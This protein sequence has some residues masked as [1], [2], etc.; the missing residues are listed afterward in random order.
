MVRAQPFLDHRDALIA[1][2]LAVLA[3]MCLACSAWAA[4]MEAI[5]NET[6]DH[7]G[8][9][10]IKGPLITGE[11]QQDISK[12]ATLAAA[13][14]NPVAVFLDSPGGSAWAAVEIGRIIRKRGFSTVVIDDATC[15]S[16]CAL[17]WMAGK[18]R[19]MGG[20]TRI[21]FH[22]ARDKTEVS[23]YGNAVIG[24]Y[25][26]ELGITDFD[27]IVHLTKASPYS[28]TWLTM[29]EAVRCKI[30]AK[31]FSFAHKQWSWAE[32]LMTRPGY[33]PPGRIDAPGHD[34]AVS[35]SSQRV[36]NKVE[37]LPER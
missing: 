20:N 12:F 18:E 33:G 28:M 32:A 19:Y 15:N 1:S 24:A 29:S 21:G 9:I 8:V 7:P 27:V 35:A 4:E 10:L 2:Y 13:Q 14:T 22:A 3:F 37:N 16:A 17:I 6:A 5:V 30:D 34:P 26:Y 25:F 31:A 23:S 11:H 36:Q